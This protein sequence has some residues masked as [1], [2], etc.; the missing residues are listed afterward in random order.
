MP[1]KKSSSIFCVPM[2]QRG[3]RSRC[4]KG[5]GSWNIMNLEEHTWSTFTYVKHYIKH[6][7]SRSL[8]K[9]ID[10]N[11]LYKTYIAVYSYLILKK[12]R[13]MKLVLKK[14]SSISL[15]LI[16]KCFYLSLAIKIRH[17]HFVKCNFLLL[18]FCISYN[19]PYH[20]PKSTANILMYL[21]LVSLLCTCISLFSQLNSH[22]THYFVW[23]LF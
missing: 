2:L 15:L 11:Y 7:L 12:N 9:K 4:S 17:A 21:L 18:I 22:S 3:Q 8:P 6:L 13:K 1:H 14:S 23:F 20:K 10:S 19:Q 16:T 5:F